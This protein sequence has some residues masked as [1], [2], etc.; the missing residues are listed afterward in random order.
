MRCGTAFLRYQ[1]FF[2]CFARD[3]G[4]FLLVLLIIRPGIQNSVIKMQVGIAVNP[5]LYTGI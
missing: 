5:L 3:S 1:T 4:V 2:L